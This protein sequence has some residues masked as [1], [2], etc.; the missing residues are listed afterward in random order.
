MQQPNTMKKL[1]GFL[2]YASYYRRYIRNF[3]KLASPLIRASIGTNKVNW[4]E[5]CQKS[6]DELKNLLTSD[7]VL[8]LPDF[9]KP[10]RLDTDA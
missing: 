9:S 6:F 1:K 10:F 3:A 8:Q 5:E 7:L 2:G 4:N